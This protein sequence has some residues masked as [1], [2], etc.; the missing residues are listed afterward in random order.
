M[1]C[2]NCGN[3]FENENAVCPNCGTVATQ[4]IA[5]EA[6]APV[7]EAAPAK[8]L[9]NKTIGLIGIAAVAVIIILVLV[10]AFSGGGGLERPL[11]LSEKILFQ[12]KLK[13]IEDFY[14][15]AYWT[16]MDE[17][18]GEKVSDV[19]DELEE[20]FEEGFDE[21]DKALSKAFG[22]NYKIKYKIVNK[23][24]AST[25]TADEIKDGLKEKYDIA[26]K[27]VK[28]CMEL[29]IELTIKGKEDKDTEELEVHAVKIGGDWYYTSETGTLADPSIILEAFMNSEAVMEAIME[30][31]AESLE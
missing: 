14:P 2:P 19:I 30:S 6:V 21:I 4:P 20:D 28:K 17:E 1:F 13:K 7:A 10:I 31:A 15:K 5:P 12:Q 26:K 23:E 25:K 8:K 27:D 29:E 16:Y 11:E 9:D 22:D 18:N 24:N 3:Q